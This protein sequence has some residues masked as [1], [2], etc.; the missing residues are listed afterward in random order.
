[1]CPACGAT[2]AV[3]LFESGDHHYRACTG[4]G[5]GRLDPIP[6]IDPAEFYDTDYFVG[7]S[8][9]GGY[10]DYGIDESVHRRNAQDRLGR[11]VDAGSEPPGHIIEIGSGYGYFL[12]EAR[13]R[14]WTV[15]G[16]DVSEHA[17][18]RAADL[19][20]DLAD[21]AA[22][23]SGPADV[24]AAF[25]V[26]EHMTDPFPVLRGAVNLVRPGGLIIVETWDRSHWMARRL[27]RHWQQVS[28]P[29]VV[30]LFTGEGLTEMAGRLGL[31]DVEIRPTP[32]Y[33][34]VGAVA[35]QLATGRA[36]LRRPLERIGSSRLGASP[37]K[38]GFGDLV[39]LTARRPG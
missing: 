27:G 8:I 35:G 4:C 30:Y 29:S 33:V 32:K 36:G 10:A 22:G 15:S 21:D 5:S 13:R 16:S 24:L 26:V 9:P 12:D 37:I 23:V 17:R 14:G 25:Q 20:I 6:A 1:M 7:G 2:T 38:Y 28:P 34:S 39:T 31:I 3:P 19:G 11:I 18:T